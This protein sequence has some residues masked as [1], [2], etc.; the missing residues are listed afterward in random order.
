MTALNPS[1][2][3]HRPE[4]AGSGSGTALDNEQACPGLQFFHRSRVVVLISHSLEG[5]SALLSDCAKPH[6][7]EVARLESQVSE[8]LVH[9]LHFQALTLGGCLEI[10]AL[11]VIRNGVYDPLH[12]LA[13]RQYTFNI[14]SG[15]SPFDCPVAIAR[16]SIRASVN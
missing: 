6:H 7:E 9:N 16:Y 15:R 2:M 11:R 4:G 14:A 13:H 5:V 3:P 10:V 12:F 8:A 1:A